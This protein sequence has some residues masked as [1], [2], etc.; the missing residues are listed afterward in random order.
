MIYSKNS[1]K[2][3]ILA[4]LAGAAMAIAAPPPAQQ[5]SRGPLPQPM[6][7]FAHSG[8]QHVYHHATGGRQ[9]YPPSQPGPP[10]VVNADPSRLQDSRDALVGYDCSAPTMTPI[11]LLQPKPCEEAKKLYFPAE[12]ERAQIIQG[13]AAVP[14]T[15]TQ[16]LVRITQRV[17]RC[18][19]NSITYGHHVPVYHS[20]TDVHPRQCRQALHSGH[21]TI[22]GQPLAIE[23]GATV[24][25]AWVS[26]GDVDKHGGCKVEEGFTTGGKNFAHSYEQTEAKITVKTLPGMADPA[27]GTLTIEGRLVVPYKTGY[28][29]DMEMGTLAWTTNPVNCTTTLSEIFAGNVSVA[30]KRQPSGA[31]SRVGALVIVESEQSY[32]YAGLQLREPRNLCGRHCYSTQAGSLMVC[33]L[34]SHDGPIPNL[35]FN[36]AAEQRRTMFETQ[37]SYLHMDTNRRMYD[38]FEVVQN[39]VCILERKLLQARL[40]SIA[41]DNDPYALQDLF[42][43]GHDLL[44]AG[45]VV[46]LVRC[47][48]V[49][50]H[51]AAFP[52][53]TQ[54]VPVN[55]T[56]G[57]QELEFLDPVSRL[58]RPLPTVVPCSPF[59]PVMWKLNG[60]WYCHDGTTRPCK[61]PQQLSINST[62]F[63]EDDYAKGLGHNIYSAAQQKQHS[64]YREAAQSRNA[65]LSVITNH[66]AAH[67]G[68]RGPLD[69]SILGPADLDVISTAIGIKLIPLFRIFGYYWTTF[70]GFL[71]AVGIV[72]A[73]LG[74][75]IRLFAT[76]RARGLGWHMAF[77]LWHTAYDLVMLPFRLSQAAAEALLRP[78]AADP[79]PEGEPGNQ[80]APPP[81]GGAASNAPNNDVQ[82]LEK[83]QPQLHN[84]AGAFFRGF[85]RDNQSRSRSAGRPAAA[86]ADPPPYQDEGME[87][88]ALGPLER[89]GGQSAG[90]RTSRGRP[91][92][93]TYPEVPHSTSGSRNYEVL[94]P[95]DFSDTETEEVGFRMREEALVRVPSG[96]RRSRG[97]STPGPTPADRAAAA[98]RT[99]EGSV[100]N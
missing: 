52:N 18:G 94:R 53:C 34:Q 83:F 77:A 30:R 10:V 48:P 71:F 20:T 65:I 82:T 47:K 36:S 93:R 87:M 19:F 13:G 42:G 61:P 43:Q 46:Y 24:G 81:N 66:A 92:R 11:S 56:E 68:T 33:F 58:L 37:A 26:Q 72:K 45:A 63:Q 14:V 60:A 21:I 32:Q 8:Q 88:Q 9:H 67:R 79:P 78:E 90:H 17:V 16:C 1:H 23:V 70:I 57:G 89:H 64:Q 96:R 97:R 100:S 25:R 73:L 31:D 5:E 6:Q 75:A 39:D 54:E 35:A 95:N 80:G 98:A 7:Y 38:R 40:H 44:R 28:V 41:A 86:A 59:A 85:G 69:V 76:Y 50:V 22:N 3:A 2:N 4:L 51:R 15:V 62:V 55:R 29:K 12:T 74:I 84:P 99:Q 49:L 27:K 91:D